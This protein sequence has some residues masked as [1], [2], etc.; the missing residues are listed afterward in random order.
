MSFQEKYGQILLPRITPYDE[1]EEVNYERYGELIELVRELS[2]EAV[3][4]CLGAFCGAFDRE[5]GAFAESWNRTH[6]R[7]VHFISTRGWVPEEPLLP[8]RSG[9]RII[10]DRLVPQ[11]KD[12]LQTAGIREN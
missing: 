5:L 12:I 11:L 3:V 9:H 2:P 7:P 6:A 8:L 10:A 4:V 1:N